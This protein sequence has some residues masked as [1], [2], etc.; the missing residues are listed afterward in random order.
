MLAD[1]K[2]ADPLVRLRVKQARLVTVELIP[3]VNVSIPIAESGV[4]PVARP[5]SHRPVP[6]AELS[7]RDP[8]TPLADALWP[9]FRAR[10]DDYLAASQ[11]GRYA[12]KRTRTLTQPGEEEDWRAV[13]T[14]TW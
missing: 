12:T 5:E 7:S 4:Q 8:L 6:A 13:A 3:G 2:L 9:H 11:R 10:L 1:P 14:A